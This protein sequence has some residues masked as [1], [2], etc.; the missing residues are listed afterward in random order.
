[1][2][3]IAKASMNLEDQ[4]TVIDQ[5]CHENGHRWQGTDIKTVR[6]LSSSRIRKVSSIVIKFATPKTANEAISHSVQWRTKKHKAQYY[7]CATRITQCSKCQQFGHTSSQCCNTQAC[8]Y[9]AQPHSVSRCP[10]KTEGLP[11]KY[12]N[13][14]KDHPAWNRICECYAA[15]L[16]HFEALDKMRPKY[17]CEFLPIT[18]DT[19]ASQ[20]YTSETAESELVLQD[21][22]QTEIKEEDEE[23][24]VAR[25]RRKRL[26]SI[27][28]RRTY[29]RRYIRSPSISVV[30]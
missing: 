26:S 16:K 28:H 23:Q 6:W 19:I 4:A 1:M 17:Y 29:K 20:S 12:A 30:G 5:L 9:C 25:N 15:E 21:G 18:P 7:D 27:T 10:Q 22:I 8:E 13:C 24:P 2:H 11:P 14:K 3:G